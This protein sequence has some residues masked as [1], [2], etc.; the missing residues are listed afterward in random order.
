MGHRSISSPILNKP[1][2]IRVLYHPKDSPEQKSKAA[3]E[4]VFDIHFS[5]GQL[6][7]RKTLDLS[8][9]TVRKIHAL[10]P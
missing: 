7:V 4:L 1:P 8:N 9:L 6:D 3:P 5:F 10:L 2:A